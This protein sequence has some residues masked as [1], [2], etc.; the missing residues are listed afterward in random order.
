MHLQ[1]RF[2]FYR[3]GRRWEERDSYIRSI[4]GPKA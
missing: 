4:G 3:T 2:Y 1:P